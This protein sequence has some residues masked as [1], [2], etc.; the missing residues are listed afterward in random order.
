MRY[1]LLVLLVA[2]Q[3]MAKPTL[4]IIGDST[5]RNGTPGQMGWGDPLVGE[6]DPARIEV[7]NRAIGGRSSRTFLTEGRWDAILANLQAGDYVLMQFGHNDGGDYFTGDRPRASIPDIGEETK[8]GTVAQTG[9]DE[10]VHSYGWYLRHICRT[11]KAAGA[12]PIVVC[13]QRGL[14]AEVLPRPRH[15]VSDHSAVILSRMKAWLAASTGTVRIHSRRS[16]SP[17]SAS[18]SDTI[19]SDEAGSSSPAREVADWALTVMPG[20]SFRT[21]A[22]RLR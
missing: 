14:R 13:R 8:S 19:E 11:A 10:V 2:A 12:Q 22:A 16:N 18:W 15:A 5:V 17:R 3:A 4:W 6:F 21:V 9:K 20:V 1:L 7:V